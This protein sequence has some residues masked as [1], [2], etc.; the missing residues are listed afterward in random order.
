[1]LVK[2]WLKENLAKCTEGQQHIFKRMYSPD[3][4]ERNIDE[5]LDGMDID[6]LLWA[7]RQVEQTLEKNGE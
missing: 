4:M 2:D 7:K 5:V 3:N 6:Q 1:M